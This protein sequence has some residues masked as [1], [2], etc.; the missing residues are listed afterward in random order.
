MSSSSVS[1]YVV[2]VVR[3]RRYQQ[4]R[5]HLSINKKVLPDDVCL[6]S[7]RCSHQNRCLLLRYNLRSWSQYLVW[8]WLADI[9]MCCRH[10]QLRWCNSKM[11][12]KNWRHSFFDSFQL[13][14]N[15]CSCDGLWPERSANQD[16]SS[17]CFHLGCFCYANH[18]LR[19]NFVLRSLVWQILELKFGLSVLLMSFSRVP[20]TDR[21]F[22]HQQ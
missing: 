10:V 19:S 8:T 13:S 16:S 1:W 9:A 17:H 11:G 18:L 22:V 5:L 3:F 2:K 6:S 7:Q 15:R 20:A 4:K 12:R 14:N 21:M